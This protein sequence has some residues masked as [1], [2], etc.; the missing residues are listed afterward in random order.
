MKQQELKKLLDE[1]ITLP[2]ENEW[3]EFK[4]NNFEPQSIGEYISAISNSA[5]LHRKEF[6]YLVFGIEDE[7]HAIKGTTFKPRKR[8]VGNEE[9]ENWLAVK[10]TP[11]IDFKIF[12]FDN[13]GKNIVIFRIDPASSVPVRFKGIEYIRVGSYKKKLADHPEK[14]RKIWNIASNIDWSAQICE[15]A[16]ID[17]L[18]PKAILKARKEYKKKFPD[19][20]NDVDKW[21]DIT[22]LNKAMITKRGKITRTA[23]ILLGR[24]ESEHFISPSAAKMS[25]ILKD[26]NNNARDYEHFGPPFILNTELVLNKI[27]NLKY[28]YLPDNTL[29][30][31]ETTMYEPYVIREALHNCIAHQDYELQG[32]INVVEKPDEVIFT[33]LG[34]FIPGS[35]E[36][37]IDEDAPQDY[38]NK[39]LANAM[40]N[41]NMIDTIGSGIKKM[42]EY[43]IKRYFPLPGYDL[44]KQDRVKVKII[45]KVIDE[46]YTRMLINKTDLSIKTIMA[47]DKVQKKE[48]PTGEELKKLRNQKLVEGRYPNL[49]VAAKIAAAAGDKSTYIKYRAFDNKY[50]K[51]LVY[52]YIKK[53]GPVNRKEIDELLMSKLP[54]VLN[55]E[56]RRKKISNLI[57]VM[58]KKEKIIKNEGSNHN[59]KWVRIT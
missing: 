44:N 59:P 51:D 30:P 38:R 4:I 24:D 41:L 16:T 25:W 48:K 43:Q 7:T 54:D 12:E 45:G 52:E 28:R 37:V 26:E 34:S 50:Y 21:N 29:F 6:G 56:Q 31:I 35:V 57:F 47:L 15:D 23:I 55:E 27:R 22:F 58:S 11:K 36:A 39:F 17:D 10:L 53:F 2:S 20:A 3:V 42:F 18:E 49:F 40:V 13:E 32:R 9:L 8:K 19:K 14:A 1:L 46:N 33:N 5:C